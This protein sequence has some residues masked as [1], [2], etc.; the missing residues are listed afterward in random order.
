MSFSSDAHEPEQLKVMKYG[1]KVARRG[2]LEKKDLLNT[3]S[4]AELENYENIWHFIEKV[5]NKKRLHSALDYMSPDQFELGVALN[6][7]A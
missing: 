5:Y 2:W 1:V 3:L 6:T 4:L 7:V